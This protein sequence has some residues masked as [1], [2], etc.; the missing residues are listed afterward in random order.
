M[1]LL[2]LLNLLYKKTYRCCRHTLNLVSQY[3]S[4]NKTKLWFQELKT[5]MDFLKKKKKSLTFTFLKRLVTA[6]IMMDTS[7]E[8]WC[9]SMKHSLFWAAVC[10]QTTPVCSLCFSQAC[11]RLDIWKSERERDK[12]RKE[13]ER[14]ITKIHPKAWG[15]YGEA[16]ALLL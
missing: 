3:F 5:T 10:P 1:Q 2:E 9:F 14:E 11:L 4:I 6:S 12:E 7:V 13:R 15:C 8:M 16:G